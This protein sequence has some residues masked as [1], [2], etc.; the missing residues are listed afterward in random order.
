MSPAWSSGPPPGV[1]VVGLVNLGAWAQLTAVSTSRLAPIPEQISDAQAVTL[2]TAGLTALR[3]L[4]VAGLLLAKQ[5]LITGATGGVGRIAVQLAHAS[6]ATVSA[7]V[8]D[9]TASHGLLRSL[10]ARQVIEQFDGDFDLI[11]DGVGGATFGQAIGHLTPHG[12]LVNIATQSAEETITFHA[13]P[14]DR[15]YGANDLHPEPHPRT[16][17]APQRDQRSQSPMFAGHR[18]PVGCPSSFQ[19]RLSCA[20]DVSCQGAARRES[21][22]RLR[23]RCCLRQKASLSSFRYDCSPFDG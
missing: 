11:I 8:R 21:R 10:G 22:P 2:P 15:A 18:L 13:A 12:V 1:R 17:L 20:G 7:L 4:E 5:V 23:S 6:G 19:N 16:Q 9:A 3:A 14:F